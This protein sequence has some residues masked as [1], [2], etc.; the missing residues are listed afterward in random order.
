LQTA[1]GI[2]GLSRSE[3]GKLL[4][5]KEIYVQSQ[6]NAAALK[7]TVPPSQSTGSLTVV[8]G[9]EVIGNVMTHGEVS[10]HCSCSHP[11][12]ASHD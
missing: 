5:K 6:Q 9:R 7:A 8:V 3:I 4:L 10:Q 2:R 1:F 11:Q 12:Y